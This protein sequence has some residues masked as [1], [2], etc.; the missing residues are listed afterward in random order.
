MGQ[1]CNLREGEP[2]TPPKTPEQSQSCLLPV[3]LSSPTSVNAGLSPGRPVKSRHLHFL[4]LFKGFPVG[5]GG[6]AWS[7]SLRG[8]GREADES[9]VEGGP[10]SGR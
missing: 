3:P 2:G 1:H 7:K 5:G 6:T 8:L 10:L 4:P 9:S